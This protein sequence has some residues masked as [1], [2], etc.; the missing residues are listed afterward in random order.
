MDLFEYAIEGRMGKEVPLALRMR[1]RNLEE[2]VGQEEV[3]GS[4]SL[5]RRAVEKD[6]LRSAIFWGPPGSGKTTL[7]MIIAESTKSHFVQVKAVNSGVA[8]LR[9]IIEEARERRL[10]EGRGTILFI[11]EIHRFNRAQQDV[12]LPYVEDGTVTLIGATTENPYFEVNSSLV[13]RSAVFRLRP[14]R[15]EEIERILRRALEDK[16]RGLGEMGLRV[17]RDALA[18]IAKAAGGDARVALNILESA[19]LLAGGRGG[20]VDLEVAEKAALRKAL[21]YDRDGDLHYDA[22]SAFIKSM[23]GSDPHAAVYWL[24]RMLEAGEDPRFIARRMV[25]FASEDV[26]LADGKALQIALAAAQAVEF[27]GLP[28]AALN[29]AHAALYLSLAPKSNSV[30]TALQEARRALEEGISGEVPLHLRDSHH[31]ALRKHGHG[32]G[33][34]YPHHFPRGFVRQQYLPDGLG[35]I[36]LYHPGEEGEER[37]LVERWKKRVEGEGEDTAGSTVKAPKSQEGSS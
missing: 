32:M 2:F 28:E 36:E 12:L 15:E 25:I 21:L 13:S 27:V 34:L 30:L 17:E 31:P 33:Y 5:L 23:R 3:V 29:L 20:N 11:D 9:K 4:G 37:E 26:G 1:P 7:A 18:H 19:A 6:E 22:T 35:Q 24:A 10:T 16:N 14:L 8:E